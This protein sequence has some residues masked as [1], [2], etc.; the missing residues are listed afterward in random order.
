MRGRG[1]RVARCFTLRRISI[2]GVGLLKINVRGSLK[3][4]ANKSREKDWDRGHSLK[5]NCVCECVGVYEKERKRW[6]GTEHKGKTG[7]F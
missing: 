4:N 5:S 7:E 2:N 1:L 6:S 3:E